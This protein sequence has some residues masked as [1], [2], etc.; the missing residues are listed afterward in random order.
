MHR[1][2]T[3]LFAT[4][5]STA[6]MA[7][8]TDR[9]KVSDAWSR[10]TP[11]AQSSAAVYFTVENSGTPDRL[12]AESTPIADKSE[13]H[14][15]TMDNGIMRMRPVTEPIAIDPQ[16]PFKAGPNGYHLMLTGLKNPLKAGDTFPLLLTFEHAGPLPVTVT[17]RGPA[18]FKPL[19]GMQGMKMDGMD[20]S[21]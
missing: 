15:S 10:A 1:L 4:C 17:V 13:M 8:T 11:T 18:T 9:I 2:T 5:I 12:T 6:A 21:H 16:H 7:Q 3:A 14:D 20:M 19:G